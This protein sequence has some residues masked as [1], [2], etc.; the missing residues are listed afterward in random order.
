MK[1][2]ALKAGLFAGGLGIAGIAYVGLLYADL[3]IYTVSIDNRS[4]QRLSNVQVWLGENKIG[5]GALD[6][7]ASRFTFGTPSG[8]GGLR[9]TFE[10]NG[11]VIDNRAGLDSAA[12]SYKLTIWPEFDMSTR[13]VRWGPINPRIDS[14]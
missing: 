7:N 8:G 6:F 3:T 2:V 14:R 1:C 13:Q 12:T 4:Q 9:V 10:V 11:T 5:Q